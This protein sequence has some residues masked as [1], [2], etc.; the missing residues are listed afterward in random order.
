MGVESLW[1]KMTRNI[2]FVYKLWTDIPLHISVSRFY[3]QVHDPKWGNVIQF[4]EEKDR[5]TS[6]LVNTKTQMG[7]IDP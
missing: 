2:I 5:L 6:I 4:H 3:E 7:Q 1:V